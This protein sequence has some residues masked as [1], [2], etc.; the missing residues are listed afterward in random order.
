MRPLLRGLV[1]VLALTLAM[2][3]MAQARSFA[4]AHAD[5]AGG[6]ITNVVSCGGAR[7]GRTHSQPHRGHG[8]T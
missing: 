4:G 5:A 2:P 3:S 8:K 7:H 1:L 6:E